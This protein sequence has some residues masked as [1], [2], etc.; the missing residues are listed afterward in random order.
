MY[1][2]LYIDPRG[3]LKQHYVGLTLI[4]KH[5]IVTA[6]FICTKTFYRMVKYTIWRK[7]EI[8]QEAMQLCNK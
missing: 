8:L 7:E 4:L 3:S 1:L 2:L 6:P 5:K